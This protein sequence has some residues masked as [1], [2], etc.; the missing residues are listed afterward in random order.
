ME[1]QIVQVPGRCV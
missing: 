1:E